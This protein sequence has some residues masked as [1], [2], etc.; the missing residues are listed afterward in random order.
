[1]GEI[2]IVVD[3]KGKIRVKKFIEWVKKRDEFDFN[4]VEIKLFK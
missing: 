3:N 1:M 2:S 4:I